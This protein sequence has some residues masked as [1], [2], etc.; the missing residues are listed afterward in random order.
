MSIIVVVVLSFCCSRRLHRLGLCYVVRLCLGRIMSDR[1][2]E[3]AVDFGHRVGDTLFNP[4]SLTHGCM[5]KHCSMKHTRRGALGASYI[6]QHRALDVNGQI[7]LLHK[8]STTAR[9]ASGRNLYQGVLQTIALHVA[10]DMSYR[11]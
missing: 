3:E 8:A 4:A 11:W 10:H 2:K 7:G 6:Q 9:G 1:A 5:G